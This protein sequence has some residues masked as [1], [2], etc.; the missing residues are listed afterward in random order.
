MN[1]NYANINC[2]NKDELES[3]IK[4]IY[5]EKKNR[6]SKYRHWD[7][8]E[9][10]IIGEILL[11]DNLMKNYKINY[12]DLKFYVNEYG[13]PYIEN[14][15]IY[16]NISHSYDYVVSITADNP[17]GID[18]EKIRDASIKDINQFATDNEKKYILK[19]NNNIMKRL[20]SIYTLK[21]A[22][23]KMKGTNLNNI[24]NVEFNI[25]DNKINCSDKNVKV[26]FIN[27]IKDYKIAY[28]IEK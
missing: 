5:Y 16:F 8:K 21:E 22:Y 17:I 2:Y 4:L 25:K 12:V 18:I 9:K 1:Y 24:K 7:T 23:F 20:W 26:G 13:K 10:S 6:I 28:C 11:K 15:N 3:F 14:K 19:D 27:E